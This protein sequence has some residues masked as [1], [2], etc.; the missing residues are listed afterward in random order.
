M[1]KKFSASLVPLLFYTIFSPTTAILASVITTTT[2]RQLHH[3]VAENIKTFD[4][5]TDV[6]NI[7]GAEPD[8]INVTNL[9]APNKSANRSPFDQYY[10]RYNSKDGPDDRGMN[11]DY[12]GRSSQNSYLHPAD[13]DNQHG[14]R[15]NFDQYWRRKDHLVNKNNNRHNHRQHRDHYYRD[16]L[17]EGQ[18]H[19]N[20]SL[21]F[22]KKPAKKN[23]R[24]PLYDDPQDRLE[25]DQPN[26]SRKS[27][28]FTRKEKAI[29]QSQENPRDILL[30]D[31][32]DERNRLDL[33][34]FAEKKY[35]E[36]LCA[37]VASALLALAQ[38]AHQTHPKLGLKS[39]LEPL[40][41]AAPLKYVH[42]GDVLKLRLLLD[43][44]TLTGFSSM[45]VQEVKFVFDPLE[46]R[47]QETHSG[48]F[49]NSTKTETQYGQDSSRHSKQS[50]LPG[51]GTFSHF[52][53]RRNPKGGDKNNLKQ[54]TVSDY[55]EEY[56]PFFYQYGDHY[57]EDIGENNKESQ[58]LDQTRAVDNEKSVIYENPS[59]ESKY[60]KE[61]M[62]PSKPM[63][64]R[65]KE[66]YY[67]DEF[68]YDYHYDVP[69][70]SQSSGKVR[71]RRAHQGT[72]YKSEQL[73]RESIQG[74]TQVFFSSNKTHSSLDEA[75]S[76]EGL[77][78]AIECGADKHSCGDTS[79]SS[80]VT[81]Q[82]KLGHESSR[83][84]L[85]S[86]SSSNTR[87]PKNHQSEL[88]KS[89]EGSTESRSSFNSKESVD[90]IESL[91]LLART[92]NYENNF[93]PSGIVS[94]RM[95]PKPI[96]K[97]SSYSTTEYQDK[98]PKAQETR[99][100]QSTNENQSEFSDSKIKKEQKI[101]SK[102]EN[103]SAL[104]YS[105]ARKT[106]K[107]RSALA[108]SVHATPTAFRSLEGVIRVAF[109]GLHMT[110]AYL[111]R[112]S[113]GDVFS[114]RE[115]GKFELSTPAV[116][117]VSRLRLVLPAAHGRHARRNSVGHVVRVE[118]QDSISPPVLTL[119]P[120]TTPPRWLGSQV[121]LKLEELAAGIR[122]HRDG[123][124]RH[125][126]RQWERLVKRLVALVAPQPGAVLPRH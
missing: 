16:R 14:K 108:G 74:I 115:K 39:P 98:S 8:A 86:T 121:Q 87:G 76:V 28:Q 84:T 81:V 72:G 25:R 78:D 46:E 73:S 85:E 124:V 113:A 47:F 6:K 48:S 79:P 35:E 33:L 80:P 70:P 90:A 83:K 109:T 24:V 122:R 3:S 26:L 82:L 112:G 105:N 117:L 71:H 23:T 11:E 21:S 12:H 67:V 101:P 77:S 68:D 1:A 116:Y 123:A 100:F 29:T 118:T 43:N 62:Y 60:L 92:N 38:K 34:E 10:F 53:L 66:S 107:V 2:N 94:I 20:V 111:V 91:H 22:Y 58:E 15:Q 120:D 119:T 45:T 103:L 41:G 4:P 7:A 63:K 19:G 95:Y 106:R 36:E 49:E 57:D 59:D 110:S 30:D 99:Q 55:D 104:P 88:N 18:H 37:V 96:L 97:N 27:L 42:E 126:V 9:T 40:H 52:E 64:Q 51:S 54:V 69:H 50:D 114:F 13:V 44:I 17:N 32:P 102:N 5:Y 65:K 75:E 31:E 56:D 61:N 89:S 125:L 93:D